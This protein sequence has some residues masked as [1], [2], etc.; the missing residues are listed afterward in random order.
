MD[1]NVL[2]SMAYL[3]GRMRS[4]FAACMELLN[5]ASIEVLKYAHALF[6]ARATLPDVREGWEHPSRVFNEKAR[7][8][9]G[10][11]RKPF[12]NMRVGYP[13]RRN[14]NHLAMKRA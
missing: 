9:K 4:G 1:E 14:R 8:P 11:T 5:Y 7:L 2:S 6:D 13:R 10:R 12:R 3:E